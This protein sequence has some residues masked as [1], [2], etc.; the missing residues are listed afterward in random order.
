MGQFIPSDE[1]DYYDQANL[2]TG[3]YEPFDEVTR[4]SLVHALREHSISIDDVA[5]DDIMESYRTLHSYV[6]TISH[7]K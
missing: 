7:S 2:P 1:C 5:I 6:V 4:K 3:I